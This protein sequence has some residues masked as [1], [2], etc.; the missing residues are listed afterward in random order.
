MIPVP[1]WAEIDS[2][3]LFKYSLDKLEKFVIWIFLF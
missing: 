1:I 3:S 2:F